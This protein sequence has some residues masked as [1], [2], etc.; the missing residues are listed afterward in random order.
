M[1]V[2][3]AYFTALRK[4]W[5]LI[6]LLM[7]V[8]RASLPCGVFKVESLLYAMMSDSTT[9]GGLKSIGGECLHFRHIRGDT[10]LLIGHCEV[11]SVPEAISGGDVP[12]PW[13]CRVR[14]RRSRN[15]DEM[16]II[17]VLPL[18][19]SQRHLRLTGFQIMYGMT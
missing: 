13:D 19:D 2:N 11:T 1:P 18:K 7:F 3:A 10:I 16:S 6:F 12:P 5:R 8:M 15:D 9:C 14:L 4:P 17:L